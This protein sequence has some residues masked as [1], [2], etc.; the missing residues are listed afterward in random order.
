MPDIKDAT[1]LVL[2]LVSGFDRADEGPLIYA[3]LVHLPIVLVI[4]V[5]HTLHV[6]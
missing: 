3:K 1:R 5:G 6:T 2:D 4:A